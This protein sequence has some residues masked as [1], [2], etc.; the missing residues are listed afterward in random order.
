MGGTVTIYTTVRRYC[1]RKFDWS[2]GNDSVFIN[3]NLEALKP[4][5]EHERRGDGGIHLCWLHLFLR[6]ELDCYP[7]SFLS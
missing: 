2:G 1:S 5:F 4:F 3:D 6:D 7:V